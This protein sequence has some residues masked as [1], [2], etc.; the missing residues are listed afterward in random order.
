[1]GL[2]NEPARPAIQDESFGGWKY[3][4]FVDFMA[5]PSTSRITLQAGSAW[6]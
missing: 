6:C 1:M 5:I 2:V 4:I 3:D